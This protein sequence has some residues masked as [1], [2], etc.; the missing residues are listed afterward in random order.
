MKI[1]HV[2]GKMK[3]A[4]V[5]AVVFNY[6][7]NIND[8]DFSFDILYD[9]DST[10]QPPKDLIDKGITFI[11][12]PPYQKLNE[13]IKKVGEICR[14]NG[15][16]AIHVHMNSLSVFALYAAKKA[17]VPY[18]I[19]HNHTTSSKYELAK[20]A[21]K[22][23]LRPFNPIFA[24]SYAACGEKAARWMFGN[25]RFENGLV[26]VINNA[27][28][29]DRFAFSKEGRIF[30]RNMHGISDDAFVIGN[31]GRFVAQKNHMFLI[32]IFRD[33]LKVNP[34]SVL[35]LLG[36][37]EGIENVRLKVSQYGITDKVIFA[38]T[39]NDSA[40][41][42]SAM[43]VFCLPSIYEGL[44]VVALEAQAA[45]LPCLISDKV[46]AECAV[47]DRVSFISIECGT[48]KWVD[49]LSSVTSEG[50][51]EAT[52]LFKNGKFDIEKSAYELLNFYKS[53]K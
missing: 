39:T 16:D 33:F 51:N 9:A 5:E 2:I 14:E 45:G 3:N 31:I 20:S 36:G 43:D 52:L 1:A 34:N 46:T 29:T 8:E 12:I 13:Y 19:C 25:K 7:S 50:R 40:P 18:R 42:Y 47:T 44:P 27:I 48:E 35:L 11:E 37:G 15:Y 24:T 32:D 21:L 28:D 41:Y 38:G 53:L 10:A 23:A 26:K 30:I 4:G 22:T 49:A 6:L 17:G